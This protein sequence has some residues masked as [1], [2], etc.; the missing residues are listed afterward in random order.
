MSKK[1]VKIVFLSLEIVF[2]FVLFFLLR[3]SNSFLIL[4]QV[5]KLFLKR[6]FVTEEGKS[7]VRVFPSRIL[8]IIYLPY[9]APLLLD[10]LLT[11]P[12]SQLVGHSPYEEVAFG[13]P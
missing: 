10:Y 9:L 13:K 11:A 12:S 8:Q 2:C 7:S 4:L 3:K 6:I 5:M 1:H